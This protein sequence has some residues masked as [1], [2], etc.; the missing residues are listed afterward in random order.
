MPAFEGAKTVHALDRL[1]TVMGT[2]TPTYVFS[3]EIKVDNE[4]PHITRTP[5]IYAC[6]EIHLTFVASRIGSHIAYSPIRYALKAEQVKI[7]RW[8]LD[9]NDVLISR[10]YKVLTMVYNTQRYWIFG[11]CPSSGSFS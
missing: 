10:Y 3:S 11:L 6:Q 1:A 8:T 2:S 5:G 4:H 9:S 7:S